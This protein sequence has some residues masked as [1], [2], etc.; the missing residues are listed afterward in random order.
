MA[1]KVKVTLFVLTV[2]GWFATCVFAKPDPNFH[3]FL[4]FGQSNM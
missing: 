4:C 3:V 1:M 2:P